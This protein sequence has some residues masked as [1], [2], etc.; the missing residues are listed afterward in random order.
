MSTS[1]NKKQQQ[2]EPDAGPRLTQ[3]EQRVLVYL[4]AGLA[5]KTIASEL[6]RSRGAI[7]HHVAALLR[8]HGTPTRILLIIMLLSKP[9]HKDRTQE[10]P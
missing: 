10:S 5:D 7:R 9:G 3:M 1:K 6:N 8:K 4:L 2:A